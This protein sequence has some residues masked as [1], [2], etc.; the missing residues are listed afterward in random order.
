MSVIH[1]TISEL[2][3]F[4]KVDPGDA[5]QDDVIATLAM[6][7]GELMRSGFSRRGCLDVFFR[8]AACCGVSSSNFPY[9]LW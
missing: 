8:K 2:K 5:T 7:A 3:N 1:T 6:A 9:T 4:L